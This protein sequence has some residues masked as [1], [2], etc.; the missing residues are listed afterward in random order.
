MEYV[1]SEPTWV[2]RTDAEAAGFRR[3][4]LCSRGVMS[5]AL[6]APNLPQSHTQRPWRFAVIALRYAQ[7]CVLLS[8]WCLRRQVCKQCLPL[9]AASTIAGVADGALD[10]SVS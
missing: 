6:S 2:R 7:R 4:Q 9:H 3:E 1:V 10:G 5:E 8:M